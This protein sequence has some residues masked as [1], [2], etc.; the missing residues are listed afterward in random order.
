MYGMQDSLD[1]PL[2]RNE[3]VIEGELVGRPPLP[4]SVERATTYAVAMT[5]RRGVVGRASVTSA[6][7]VSS[8]SLTYLSALE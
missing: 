6:Y 3:A 7:S 2:R 4:R 5:H 8:L 1:R